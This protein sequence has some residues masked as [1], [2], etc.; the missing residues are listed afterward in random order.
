MNIQIPFVH[1]TIRINN[2]CNSAHIDRIDRSRLV[3]YVTFSLT[4]TRTQKKT[5]PLQLSEQG[6]VFNTPQQTTCKSQ[7]T[8][9]TQSLGLQYATSNHTLTFRNQ[10]SI[11]RYT[12][13]NF[14]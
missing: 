6:Q 8:C 7:Q 4:R 2:S 13:P 10:S 12:G 3:V 9:L 14:H 11:N 5:L 1:F